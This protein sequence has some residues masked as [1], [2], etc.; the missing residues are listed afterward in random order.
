[1]AFR[2]K[3]VQ[4]YESYMFAHLGLHAAGR[5]LRVQHAGYPV[6]ING[7]TPAREN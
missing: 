5:H 1:M 4:R 2:E 3:H 7:E 6:I